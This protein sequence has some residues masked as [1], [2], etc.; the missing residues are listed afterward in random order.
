MTTKNILKL[1]SDS[2]TSD[3]ASSRRHWAEFLNSSKESL[4]SH[5][6]SNARA[7]FTKQDERH[8]RIAEAAIQL[9]DNFGRAPKSL[10]LGEA[11]EELGVEW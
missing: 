3:V 9:I 4:A 6:A 5:K 7:F 10:V 8:I 1:A 2:I 11:A